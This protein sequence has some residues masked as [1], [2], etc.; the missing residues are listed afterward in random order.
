MRKTHFVVICLLSWLLCSAPT[1]EAGKS[2]LITDF[3]ETLQRIH[4][5]LSPVDVQD[6]Y[7]SSA[8]NEADEMQTLLTELRAGHLLLAERFRQQGARSAEAGGEAVDRH[9]AWNK[10]YKQV[11][12][13][14]VPLLENIVKA[15]KETTADRQRCLELLNQLLSVKALPLHGQLPYQNVPE[16]NLLP[17]MGPTL[18]PAYQ[19]A[20]IT[21]AAADLAASSEAPH[22][23]LITAQAEAIAAAAGKVNWDPVDLY[24]WVKNTIAT[25]WYWGCMKGAE[26][27]LRQRS[28]NAADQASLLVALLRSAGYPARYL[29]GVVSG[30]PGLDQLKE[31]TGLEDPARILS[32]LRKAGIPCEPVMEGA[33]IVNIRFEHI[34]VETLVPYANYRGNMG[35]Q[36][37]KT[38]LPLDPTIKVAGYLEQTGQI[39]LYAAASETLHGLRD[40]YLADVPAL[41]PLE[42]LHRV[43]DEVMT[44]Q[45]M[46]LP[47]DQLLFRRQQQTEHLPFLPSS[48]QVTVEAVT[49]EFA[50][51]PEELVHSIDLSIG[52]EEP[53]L[54]LNL[55]VH[56]LAGRQ[57][58]L[59]FEP[60]TVADHETIN[61]WGGLDNT[62]AYLVRLR[63]VLLLDNE[64]LAVGRDG[65][66]AGETFDLAVT[67]TGPALSTTT[68]NQVT[69]GYPLL[70]GLAAQHPPTPDTV[71][72]DSPALDSLQ[73]FAIDYVRRWNLAEQELAELLNLSIA[74]PLPTL[75]TLGG[76]LQVTELLDEPLEVDFT[77]LFVDAD[78]R[79][80]ATAVRGAVVDERERFF[81]QM[82]ALQGSVLEHQ[83]FEEN[84][85]LTAMSTARLLGLAGAAGE[86][87]LE[88]DAA[89]RATQLPQLQAPANL[90]AD[91]E[92]ALDAG[93][94]VKVPALPVGLVDW[95]G[96]GYLKEDP[97]SGAAGYM[98]SGM[99]AGGATVTNA[100]AWTD[101]LKYLFKYPFSLPPN[102]DP[103]AG[104]TLSKIAATDL[105]TG[106]VGET[107]DE[108]LTVYVRDLENVP[109][110]N[111][112]VT[113]SLREGSGTLRDDEAEP[114]GTG[115]TLTVQ[116]DWRGLARV[117]LA[118][119]EHTADNR[120][121]W[122]TDGDTYA[123]WAGQITVDAHLSS[124][125]G[126][127][128]PFLATALPDEPATLTP[129]N[130]GVQGRIL[131]Y[132]GP[133]GGLVSD[134]F[135]N[136]V[137][138]VPVRFSAEEVTADNGLCD[139]ATVNADTLTLQLTAERSCMIQLP[140]WG[141]CAEAEP[142]DALT[143][144]N[145][146]V[147]A[148]VV[149][150]GL[151][152]GSYPVT[153]EYGGSSLSTPF[154]PVT[155]TNSSQP[156]PGDA[157][158]GSVPPLSY[159]TLDAEETLVRPANQPVSLQVKTQMFA[160][161]EADSLAS[162][163]LTCGETPLNC[164][165]IAGDGNLRRIV[166]QSLTVTIDDQPATPA[167]EGRDMYAAELTLPPGDH[168][169]TVHAAADRSVDLYD[170]QCPAEGGCASQP[171]LQTTTIS[172]ERQ[173]TCT[174]VAV[175][176]LPAQLPVATNGDGTLSQNLDV[177]FTIE[178]VGY[179]AVSASFL[180]YQDGY[181]VLSMP[182]A[183]TGTVTAS[184]S[185]GFWFDPASHYE[186][187]VV[188]NYG[189]GEAEIWSDRIPLL[190]G[191]FAVRVE[192]TR[193][194]WLSDLERQR[195]GAFVLLNNDLE[196]ST[197]L[198]DDDELKRLVL[199]LPAFDGAT[200]G[201]WSLTLSNDQ[202]FAIK[203]P[204]G[205]PLVSGQD[206]PVTLPATI[207]LY[208]EGL[209]ESSALQ[210]ESFTVRFTPDGGGVFEEEV[211]VTVVHL[212]MAV[213]GNRDR[214]LKPNDPADEEYLFWIN[215]DYDYS[216]C[217][218][219]VITP[220]VCEEDDL[221]I[222]YADANDNV[223]RTRRELED[224]ARLH[225]FTGA[226]L[227]DSSLALNLRS[228]ADSMD[229]VPVLNIFKAVDETDKYLGIDLEDDDHQPDLQ[230]LEER[231]LKI[232][233]K[234]RPLAAEWLDPG[235][236]SPFLFEGVFAGNGDLV[237]TVSYL[238][239][240]VLEKRLQ[241]ELHDVTWF[242][243][244]YT[245]DATE[246]DLDP[247]DQR[248]SSI[249]EGGYESEVDEYVLYVH[250]WNMED[251]V[252]QRWTE[253]IFKRLWWLGYQGKVGLFD[254]PCRTLPSVDVLVN[255]DIS[256][257]RAWHSAPVLAGLLADRDQSIGNRYSGQVHILGH[258]Q[259]NVVAGEAINLL[260]TGSVHS[261]VASQAALS[262]SLYHQNITEISPE[263][264]AFV[265]ETP[266]IFGSYPALEPEAPYLGSVPQKIQDNRMFT[267][268]NVKDYAL[269]VAGPLTPGWE[270]NNKTRPDD[271]IGYNYVYSTVDDYPVSLQPGEGFVKSASPVRDLRFP[272]NRYEIFSFGAESRTKALGAAN[273]PAALA[274]KSR[275]LETWEY[276]DKHYSHSKQFRSNIVDEMPYWKSFALDCGLSKTFSIEGSVQ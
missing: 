107:F 25:E 22:S 28:G 6:G 99:T 69:T 227:S 120:I 174:A 240:P 159:L 114:P 180:L 276:D 166:P 61:L 187:A 124:G 121:S 151:P 48:L 221:D 127:T 164:P 30:F 155:F 138:N 14:L 7:L 167:E 5:L 193:G 242:Y 241:L 2:S 109:V 37:G 251:W 139:P 74:R 228:E 216:S 153:A 149:L 225:V 207:P 177:N 77:G 88:I 172:A 265:Y 112:A 15:P 143:M 217:L 78:L 271:S 202:Q 267:Y 17:L 44:A 110:Y 264:P 152:D 239:V 62:P 55:P 247:V 85:D 272:E 108:P 244:H 73:Q 68:R 258:S 21:Y 198:A 219:A 154:E 248:V 1:A 63:P 210:S 192:G 137:A 82:A 94:R 205:T 266:D 9:A 8:R 178:P 145:G 237:L 13:E 156:L 148:G 92:A 76:Q 275:N 35:D 129:L 79:S 27:T 234:D 191:D 11:M 95:S 136:P 261:Y 232:D 75:V 54:A 46:A 218:D 102:A 53:L 33:Q 185:Q 96:T 70:L 106:L 252:K 222:G 269:T 273:P 142:V 128:Q 150:G 66:A 211:P 184:L 194:F 51:L 204:D 87:I 250:G 56:R 197:D 103:E 213:D 134:R 160:E 133:I 45:G 165:Q 80:I 238:G 262:T 231:L 190:I 34:W 115:N 176:G 101:L 256:E 10:R 118:A 161:E 141:E 158:G 157:C 274:G 169:L 233:D 43:A 4:A 40:S 113:F 140:G 132:A 195:T 49:G 71:D 125:T 189:W 24:A 20:T 243:D 263:L 18:V 183:A 144:S 257:Y 38:W 254:W 201:N 105:Q 104:C 67:L 203:H 57:L 36:N 209:A 173:I 199:L 181:L 253:T 268:F 206:N 236:T 131:Q 186:A 97:V 86:T 168:T 89:N 130:S 100:D 12:N 179:D 259:G 223:I 91:I 93:W 229:Q 16:Q 111:A 3:S 224:F 214:E 196:T 50:A 146:I 220:D 235:Q 98:L 117:A 208:L 226:L 23:P 147:S 122:H 58:A 270:Y 249:R 245:L 182:T 29:R 81:M 126:L 200:Q 212:D 246:N 59:G 260:P 83:L 52:S 64:R 42:T 65:L 72:G 19:Q 90:I 123:T 255:Y 31:Q 230:L 84:F 41:S 116:T 47:W 32:F 171:S 119:G 135:G 175:T 170:N 39:D 60:E 162:E 163:Q 188:L 26:E 215:D